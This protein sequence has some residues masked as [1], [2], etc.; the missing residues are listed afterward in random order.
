MRQR[1]KKNNKS[2]KDRNKE[3][4]KVWIDIHTY[5]ERNIKI[6]CY[7]D[8]GMY[9]VASLKSKINILPIANFPQNFL[10]PKDFK[11]SIRN[12]QS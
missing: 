12:F 5:K 6:T 1:K 9:R 11:S 3:E 4:K 2:K 7:K 8:T 10:A